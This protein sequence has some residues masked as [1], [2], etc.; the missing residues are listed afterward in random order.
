MRAEEEAAFCLL[1]GQSARP[2]VREL[3]QLERQAFLRMA[4]KM[5]R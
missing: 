2:D 5:R 1:T 3:T 4:K